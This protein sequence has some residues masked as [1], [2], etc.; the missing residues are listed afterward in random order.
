VDSS[1][2]DFSINIDNESVCRVHKTTNFVYQ[3]LKSILGP[4]LVVYEDV[5][6]MWWY[7]IFFSLSS[8]SF[9]CLL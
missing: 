8:F 7:F 1:I 9:I 2:Q 4:A 3:M 6:C 5:L